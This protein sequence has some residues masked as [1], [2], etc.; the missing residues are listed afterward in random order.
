[1]GRLLYDLGAIDKETINGL[2]E[3]AEEAGK[4]SFA[5]AWV[6]DQGSEERAHGVT[7]DVAIEKFETEKTNFTILDAPGHRDFVPKMIAGTSQADFAVLVIDSLTGEFE[8]GLRGQTKEHALLARSIGVQRIIVAVNKMDAAEWSQDRFQ[9]IRQQMTGFLTILGFQ[10]SSIPF[11]PCSGLLGENVLSPTKDSRASWYTGPT[12]VEELDDFEPQVQAIEKPLRMTIDNVEDNIA[13]TSAPLSITGR[14]E[15]GSVQLGQDIL[16]MPTNFRTRVKSL[17]DGD[18]QPR[19]WA[20]AGDNVTLHLTDNPNDDDAGV[21]V[22]KAGHNVYDAMSRVQNVRSLTAK[23]LTFAHMHPMFCE[24]LRGRFHAPGKI[25]KMV[26]TLDKSSGE[27]L[28][29]RPKIVHPGTVVRVVV[30]LDEP[31]AL[32]VGDRIVLRSSGET[33]A[34]GMME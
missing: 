10:D 30:E 34:T 12:L 1:M 21:H 28:K 18:S 32:E 16:I 4:G 8:A 19:D 33:I 14:L 26:E 31:G 20:V 7:T 5:F 23:V 17:D 13:P 3:E 11:V 9:E 25:A 6:L 15:T 27:V 24:V 29:K 22:V 2:R